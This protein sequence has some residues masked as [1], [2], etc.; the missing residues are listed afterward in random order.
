MEYNLAH[1]FG[2]LLLELSHTAFACITLDDVGDGFG[3]KFNLFRTKSVFS[4]HARYKMTS[5]N[6]DFLLYKIARYVDYLHAVEQRL[7]YSRECIGS[8]YEQ[9]V[10]QVIVDIDVI[11]VKMT[12]LLRVE[13]FE[14]CG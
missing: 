8:G 6:L 3:C 1:H 4:G 7:R 11:V 9:Y 2:Y 10:R 14:Q 12:V 13:D 5:C